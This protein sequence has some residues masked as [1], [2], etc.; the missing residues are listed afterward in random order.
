M[1]IGWETKTFKISESTKPPAI[2]ILWF[3]GISCL[4][5]VICINLHTLVSNTNVSRWNHKNDVQYPCSNIQCTCNRRLCM[6]KGNNYTANICREWGSTFSIVSPHLLLSCCWNFYW[7]S[8]YVILYS[9]IL[10]TFDF[11]KR[12][13]YI[14]IGWFV[15]C[16]EVIKNRKIISIIRY[17]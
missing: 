5:N 17:D 10:P 8:L 6:I 3:V 11:E 14:D 15:K 13:N 1:S 16:C 12:C 4:I 9:H 2:K 7:R